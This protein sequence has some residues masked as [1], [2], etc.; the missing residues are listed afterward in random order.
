M[1]MNQHFWCCKEGRQC[2]AGRGSSFARNYS[3]GNTFET[4]FPKY[5]VLEEQE[6]VTS[7]EE[8]SESLCIVSF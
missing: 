8:C 5:F 1:Y 7:E 3:T 4:A 6:M 2:I